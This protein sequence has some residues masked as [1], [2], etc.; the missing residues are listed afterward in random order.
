MSKS[1]KT[2]DT[3]PADRPVPR[4]GVLDIAPYVPGRSKATGGSKVYKLSSN[5]TPLGPSPAAVAAYQGVAAKLE[6]Y[7]D[8]SA[9]ELRAAIADAY[10]INASRVI[11]GN[12]SDDVLA[13]ASHVFLG[14]GD[15]A[16]YSKH[17][18]NVYPILIQAAGATPVVAPEKDMTTYVDGILELVTDRTRIVYVANPNNPTG[19]YL[20]FSEI[21][22]L[23][24]ALPPRVLL[25]LDAA[26][27]E[28]VRRND[29]E[30]GIE[31][32][33]TSPNVLMTRTFSKI[34]GLAGVRLGWGYGPAEVI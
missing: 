22:R 34:Y 15:E 12:G 18:F 20:P 14:P 8:G 26:Y 28:Y 21:R 10:G 17:G 25:V 4:P 16:I 3:K 27:S 23:H 30:S 7:P 33:G 9:A 2:P 32:A 24:A 31:L 6:I 5:E 11:C 13:L 1:S 19:T 29:Y